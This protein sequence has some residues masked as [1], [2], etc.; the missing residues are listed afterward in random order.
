MP[1]ISILSKFRS[2][3][4]INYWA[5]RDSTLARYRRR[6]IISQNPS[7]RSSP[8]ASR[9]TRHTPLRSQS[10]AGVAFALIRRPHPPCSGQA[11]A[12]A[13]TKN[14]PWCLRTLIWLRHAWNWHFMVS[15]VRF[16]PIQKHQQAKQRGIQDY[17]AG[18][19]M[20]DNPYLRQPDIALSSWWQT[21]FLQQRG[22]HNE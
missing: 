19:N 18:K 1:V 20:T 6:G 2:P 22:K 21:G 10:G 5:S 11:A 7:V 4:A 17:L 9:G 15:S 12:K 13:V 14:G 16:K 3:A 8:A